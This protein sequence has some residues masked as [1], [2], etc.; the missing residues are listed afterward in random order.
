MR[1][2]DEAGRFVKTLTEEDVLS[3]FE[4]VESPFIAK[5]DVVERFDTSI[6][7]VGDRLEDLETAGKVASR[8]PGRDRIYWLTE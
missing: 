6:N 4:E 7:T 5:P 3:V 8:V 1:E 2:K